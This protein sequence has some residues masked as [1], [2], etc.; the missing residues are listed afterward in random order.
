MKRL[1]VIAFALLSVAMALFFYAVAPIVDRQMNVVAPATLPSVSPPA[2]EVHRRLTIVDLHA[3][4]LLWQRNF[5]D[6][7]GHGHVDLPRLIAGN[8]ALQMFGVVTKTPRGMNYERNDASTDNITLVAMNQRWPVDAWGSLLARARVQA[9]RLARATAR[10]DGRLV[11]VRTATDL[12]TVLAR[13]ARGDTVVGGLLGLEGA[14]ALEGRI[15][16]VDSLHALGFRSIG[17]AH[18]FDNEV[19]GSSAGVDKGGLTP[20]GRQVVQRMES[21]GML[22]DLAHVSARGVDEVLAMA[23]RPVIVSHT[24]VRATC[25]TPRNLTDDQLR[26]IAATEGVIGIGYWDGAVCDISPASIA[27]AIR[28]AVDV[29][30]V[31]HVGLG[32]DFDGATTTQ[33]DVAALAQ[34]TNALMAAGFGE[35]DIAKVMGGNAVRVLRQGLTRR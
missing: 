14:H 35:S 2:A 25:D 28:H 9:Y 31:D 3:D 7:A 23:T 22:V 12:D 19:S 30:G 1:G 13:R 17:L 6:R 15:E 33:F 5:L 18:F 32:S 21:L 16:S 29:A 24:G 27:R 8:V 26:R 4:A 34:V 10:S 11:F 20:L